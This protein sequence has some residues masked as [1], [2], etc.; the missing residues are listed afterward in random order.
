MREL[1]SQGIQDML[2]IHVGAIVLTETIDA[3]YYSGDKR[4]STQGTIKEC[5]QKDVQDRQ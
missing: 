3:L 2:L 5:R 1:V 4:I